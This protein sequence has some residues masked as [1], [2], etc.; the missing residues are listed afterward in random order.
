[1]YIKFNVLL[2]IS[3]EIKEDREMILMDK[4]KDFSIR[5][6]KI[7]HSSR[8]YRPLDLLLPVCVCVCVCVCGRRVT[9]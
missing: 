6:P 4:L 7:F 3:L 5:H 9:M 1:M 2:N 8:T